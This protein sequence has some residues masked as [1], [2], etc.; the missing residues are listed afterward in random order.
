MTRALEK[1]GLRTLKAL[2]LCIDLSRAGKLTSLAFF[3]SILAVGWSTLLASPV[4]RMPDGSFYQTW[5]DH[6]SYT[7]IFYVNQNDP[8]ASDNNSGTEDRPLLTINRAAQ[9]ARPGE[10]VRIHA[11]V[12]REMIR[13]RFGGEGPDRM[14]AYE[15]APGEQVI[16]KGSRIL[17]GTWLPARDPLEKGDLYSK[18][19]WMI[20]LPDKLFENGY[21]PFRTPNLTSPELALMPWAQER[22]GRSPYTLSRGLLFQDGQRMVQLATYEDLVHLPGSYWVAPDGRTVYIDPF[23]SGNPNGRH[24]EAAIQPHLLQPEKTGLG[25]IR[26]SGLIFEQCAN[27]LAQIGAGALYTMGGHH[28]IIENNT[29]RHVNSVGIEAGYL[30][31]EEADKTQA[32]RTDAD[33]GHT[34][35]RGNHIY[36]CGT[37]GIRST[38]VSFSL[39]E[40]NEISDCGWQDAEYEW[41][42][43]GIKLLMTHGTLVRNNRISDIRGGGGIWLDWDNRNSR[44]TGNL[45]EDISTLA[46]AIMIEASQQTNFIDHNIIW[47]IDGAGV[48]LSDSDNQLVAQNLIG[49]TTGNLVRA[50]VATARLLHGRRVTSTGNRVLNNIFVDAETPIAFDSR[51]N[52]AAYNTYVETAKQKAEVSHA[53]GEQHSVTLRAE[54]T[55]AKDTLT[56][57]PRTIPADVPAVSGCEKDYYSQTSSANLVAPGPILDLDGGGEFRIW[58]NP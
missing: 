22:R 51:T 39:V 19:L 7:R 9:L 17:T 50:N 54:V 52:V 46:N 3:I 38:T 26:V 13:P 56:W 8:R 57:Q 55:L 20:A 35:I 36:D 10:C 33:L 58:G 18:S 21:F 40:T 1:H 5:T 47:N 12:Y 53:P 43:A 14:I 28:W 30:T 44:V 48:A 11:G 6:T 23:G 4:S 37:A 42:V 25:Y 31:F 27:G 2:K 16:I 49:D 24:F 15:A 45:I 32:P 29:I 34:I 41:E